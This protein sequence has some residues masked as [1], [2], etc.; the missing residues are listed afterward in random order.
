MRGLL[1]GA[2]RAALLQLAIVATVFNPAAAAQTT[3]I[4]AIP[5]P[6]DLD[7]VLRD[8]EE[9][10]RGGDSERLA[11]LFHETGMAI[12]G[13][14]PIARGRAEIE[15]RIRGGGPL[16]LRPV[17]YAAEDEVGYVV[18]LYGPD[19]QNPR[20]RFVLALRR[21]GIDQPWLIAADIDNALSDRM[22][23]EAAV[24]RMFG[25]VWSEGDYA[26]LPE[27]L[28]PGF[29]FHFRGRAM[30]MDAAGFQGMV[31]MWRNAFTDLRFTVHDVV[32]DGQNAAARLTFTGRHTAPLMGMQPTD[33]TVEVSMMAFLRFEG[34]RIVELWE[35]YDEHGM[36][37]Q[38]TR[39][40]Q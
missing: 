10:W 28:A 16:A 6:A 18:G 4:A 36:R 7:R 14:S 19:E 1:I 38:L 25:A 15:E 21:T 2:G 17:A 27:L 32:V 20:G 8:Y 33:R 39:P 3:S 34:G 11:A 29:T 13:G 30:P 12:P 9:A 5:L 35:D 37:Q 40:A 24:R 23:I 26:A 31:Q 22:P